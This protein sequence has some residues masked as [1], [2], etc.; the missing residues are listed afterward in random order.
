LKE[1]KKMEAMWEMTTGD[2]QQQQQ[3]SLSRR[4]HHQQQQLSPPPPPAAASTTTLSLSLPQE[5]QDAMVT[6]YAQKLYAEGVLEEDNN[7]HAANSKLVEEAVKT[8]QSHGVTTIHWGTLYAR[9]RKVA[10]DDQKK[11]MGLLLHD[12]VSSPGTDHDSEEEGDEDNNIIVNDNAEEAASDRS[13]TERSPK[14]PNT[15]STT[16]QKRPRKNSLPIGRNKD[17]EDDDDENDEDDNVWDD[18]NQ[19]AT[20][21]RPNKKQKTSNFDRDD[22]NDDDEDRKR[23]RLAVKVATAM[24]KATELFYQAYHEA[25]QQRTVCKKGTLNDIVTAVEWEY[26]LPENSINRSTIRVRVMKGNNGRRRST[27]TNALTPGA[28]FHHSLAVIDRILGKKPKS[29]KKKK[30]D[31]DNTDENDQQDR[32]A[33]K[34]AQKERTAKIARAMDRATQLFYHE[35][36]QA[37]QQE[38][39][40]KKGTLDQIV[41][42]VEMEYGLPEQTIKRNSIRG[43]VM[44]GEDGSTPIMTAT[45]VNAVGHK[46]TGRPRGSTSHYEY[47]AHKP[48]DS[49]ETATA[50]VSDNARRRRDQTIQDATYRAAVLWDAA[51][52]EVKAREGEKG[53]CV[54]GTLVGILRTVEDDFHLPRGTLQRSTVNKR[55]KRGKSLSARNESSISPMTEMEPTI[56]QQC[57]RRVRNGQPLTQPIIIEL[58]TSMVEGTPFEERVMEWKRRNAYTL[59]TKLLTGG[60][61]KGFMRRHGAIILQEQQKQAEAVV[62]TALHD[63]E[64]EE[65]E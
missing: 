17:G 16:R 29:P 9:I 39:I 24:D 22:E 53:Q 48:K 34:E 26:D 30:K 52:K 3:Q 55:V 43:R 36:E 1:K 15:S 64:T 60:W 54:P 10:Q 63:N 13:T 5:V 61:Y 18:K 59:G 42:A 12:N 62:T 51:L 28:G 21:T 58:A 11:K 2:H 7:N 14:R 50:P 23:E 38:T 25:K 56:V 57:L 20:T 65:E 45:M 40:C 8:L 33:Q 44:K 32:Q 46:K 35:F 49:A 27:P 6:A 19:N 37:K 31:L 4:N 47:S 41:R